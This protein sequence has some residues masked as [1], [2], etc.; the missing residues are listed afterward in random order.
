M[1]AIGTVALLLRAR[2]E[3]A[4]VT[5]DA[6]ISMQ[7]AFRFL[8]GEGLTWTSGAPPVE[9][10]S[11][12]LW[13]LSL[14]ALGATGIDL[15]VATRILGITCTWLL[16]V[17]V[18]WRAWGRPA[19]AAIGIAALVGSGTIATWSVAGL[20]APMVALLAVASAY[21]AAAAAEGAP[22]WRA[23]VLLAALTLARVDGFLFAPV[24]AACVATRS[25]NVAV[26]IL[27]L[28]VVA[29]LAHTGFRW[30]YYGDVVPN[31][32]HVKMEASRARYE[33]GLRY[34]AIAFKWSSPLLV[35]AC[36]L[37]AWARSSRIAILLAMGGAWI[38]YLVFI[39]GDIF[40]ARR[41]WELCVAVSAATL[42]EALRDARPRWP[43]GVGF[44]AVVAFVAIQLRDGENTRADASWTR[45]ALALGRTLQRGF[46]PLDPLM[47]VHAAGALPYGSQFRCI[48]MLGLNDREIAL[49]PVR[50]AEPMIG[51]D[52]FNAEIVLRREPDFLVYGNGTSSRA[53]EVMKD[54]RAQPEFRKYDLIPFWIGK[55]DRRWVYV[56]RDSARVGISV[57][58]DRVVIP[59]WFFASRDD[60]VRVETVGRPSLQI[61]NSASVELLLDPGPWRGSADAT[62]EV[63][64]TI[65]GAE[66]PFAAPSEATIRVESITEPVTLYG[67]TLHRQPGSHSP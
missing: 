12:L 37:G 27:V 53:G 6:Y 34:V 58:A 10:Y 18:A 3:S 25:P 60:G 23:G 51:H 16:L 43:I 63:R 21:A 49:S 20:E 42:V 7:Y 32:A 41:H 13:V 30:L 65:E 29:L 33:S 11:N 40:A 56:R 45:Q 4:Y 61:D 26:R 38:A 47:A 55:R 2:A 52:H 59:A 46:A 64:V 28:P 57:E 50:N 36:V 22:P 15:T 54:L 31:V 35:G 66:G 1:L 62:G 44:V 19:V 39:G 5:D 9:G 67:V 24:V 48:D 8:H 17:L 14:A